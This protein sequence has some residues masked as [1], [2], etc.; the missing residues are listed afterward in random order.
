[1]KRI[2]LGNLIAVVAASLLCAGPAGATSFSIGMRTDN[3]HLGIRIGEAP[4]LVVVPGT[5]VYEAPG[6]PYNYF[7]YHGGY[8]LYRGGTWLWA[9][10]YNG[11]WTVIALEQV[12]R[13]ILRVP[14]EHY[15]ER[16]EHWKRGGSPPW[17]TAQRHDQ[18][19][20]SRPEK[21]HGGRGRGED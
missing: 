4:R 19:R 6:L 11:P 20:E 13:P 12:P 9:A 16:P 5:P 8:Y 7:Y 17:A 14:A 3:V 21:G 2:L 1:M 10:S 15:R 18:R